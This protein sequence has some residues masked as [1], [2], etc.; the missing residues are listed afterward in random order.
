MERGGELMQTFPPYQSFTKTARVLDY[1]RLGK[2]RVE[3]RQILN[4]MSKVGG[5]SNHP[6]VKMWRGYE[7]ALIHYSNVMIQEWVSR[8]YRNTMEIL[9]HGTVKLPP[10]VGDSAF[11]ASHRSN[12]LRKD[13]SWY[14]KFGWSESPDLPY[15]WPV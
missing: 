1:R 13:P 15:V 2:Q 9:D 10:W 5:W 12:L 11:H 6:A 3:A 14:G 4:A 8:G 7:A